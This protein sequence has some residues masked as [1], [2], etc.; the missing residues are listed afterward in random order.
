MEGEIMNTKTI[1]IAN[2]KGGV[3]KTTTTLNFGRS[4]ALSGYKVLLVD[5][6]SQGNLTNSCGVVDVDSMESTIADCILAFIAGEEKK[7]PIYAYDKNLD[8]IP[9]NIMQSTANLMMIS[10]MARE[11]ILKSLLSRSK[12]M[13]DYILIDCA[14]SLSIDLINALNAADEVLIVTTP[15][16]FSA[17]GT[18]QLRRS[19]QKVQ[20]SINQNLKI[21]GVLFNK[22]DRRTNFA[23]ELVAAVKAEWGENTR[24]FATEIPVSVRVEESQAM[25][26]AMVDYEEDN[27]VTISFL[28]FTEEYLR[29]GEV[30]HIYGKQRGEGHGQK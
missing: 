7:L 13:Y 21:A 19:I 24:I 1:A 12:G 28:S 29:K 20:R 2:Q 25:G 6:D 14:P 4:L 18:E 27:K 23:K 17:K 15:S 30:Y 22:V 11:Q 8:Y 5:F 3:G 9:S 10:E 16:Q 26:R